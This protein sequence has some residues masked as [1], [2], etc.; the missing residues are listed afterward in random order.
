MRSK[1][2]KDKG[3]FYSFIQLGQL[4]H[5]GESENAQAS[6]WLLLGDSNPGSLDWDAVIL[7]LNSRWQTKSRLKII[8]R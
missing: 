3:M 7:L 1:L 8:S 6:K 5:R 2:K 4:G